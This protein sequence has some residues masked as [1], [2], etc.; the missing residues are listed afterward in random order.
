MKTMI[1]PML[2]IVI[3][4]AGRGSRF[5]QAG[6]TDPKPLIRIGHRRMIEVVV[7]NLRPQRP[8]RFIF[9]CLQQHLE[10]YDLADI[11]TRVAPGCL[12]VSQTAVSAGAACSVLA[13]APL[14]D[15][16]APLMIANSDQLLDVDINAYLEDF[17]L[18]GL[19]G[20]MMTMGATESKWSYAR[21]NADGAV[22]SV[23]EKQVVSDDA[24]VGIYNFRHGQDF[25]RH[26]RAMIDA[27][28]K[29][30]GE[31]YVAPVYTRWYATEQARIGTWNVGPVNERMFGLGTPEDLRYFMTLPWYAQ[32]LKEQADNLVSGRVQGDACC[33]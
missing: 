27:G 17:D 21:I 8:H 24:T 1:E 33:L 26:A 30:C 22:T 19:D 20:T 31:Y 29:S 3:P 28:E 7:D 5:A 32:M 15:N 23:V 4:M 11:L 16:V 10:Q 2:N 25:C 12:V 9:I 13:A 14:I 6:W 18:R